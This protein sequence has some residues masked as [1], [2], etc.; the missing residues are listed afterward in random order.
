MYSAGSEVDDPL[1]GGA[2]APSRTPCSGCTPSTWRGCQQFPQIRAVM[3]LLSEF[4]PR[5]EDRVAAEDRRAVDLDDATVG[6]VDLRV[7]PRS[8]TIRVMGSRPS[9]TSWVYPCPT[10]T[11]RW[12]CSGAPRRVFV[13]PVVRSE[14]LRRGRDPVSPV[15]MVLV[16]K[17]R[18]ACRRRRSRPGD[19]PAGGASMNGMSCRGVRASCSRC[20][21][22]RRSA[23]RRR[24]WIPP[25]LGRLAVAPPGRSSHLDVHSAGPYSGAKLAL[26]V[27]AA[28]IAALVRR[29]AHEEPGRPAS[30]VQR[31]HRRDF[32]WPGRAGRGWSPRRLWVHRAAQHVD[33]G[34]LPPCSSA[35]Q[36][37]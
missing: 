33:D 23:I 20:R 29:L 34:R 19:H 12:R 24:R 15:F 4:L 13:K 28:A 32:R 37:R 7:M 30:L 17:R 31:D 25:A 21:S 10:S 3:E 27:V 5:T 14:P 11:A 36:P 16:R 8:P 9:S 1:A 2:A 6:E 26:L 18:M 35:A 22:R